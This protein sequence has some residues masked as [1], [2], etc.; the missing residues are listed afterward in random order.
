MSSECMNESPE[1][2]AV[3]WCSFMVNGL[4]SAVGEFVLVV[5]LVFCAIRNV[6]RT[7]MQDVDEDL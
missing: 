1:G 2:C 6:L 4:T 5:F 7:S 3:R